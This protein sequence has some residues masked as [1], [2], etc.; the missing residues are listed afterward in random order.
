MITEI[1]GCD[2]PLEAKMSKKITLKEWSDFNSGICNYGDLIVCLMKRGSYNKDD[3]ILEATIRTDNAIKLFGN[4]EMKKF[5]VGTYP[6]SEF[7]GLRILLW[8]PEEKEAKQ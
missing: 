3:T 2:L 5:M 7:H 1:R 4:W 8:E 6:N